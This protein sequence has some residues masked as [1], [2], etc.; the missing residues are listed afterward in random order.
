VWAAGVLLA[1]CGSVSAPEPGSPQITTSAVIVAADGNVPSRNAPQ[2]S[3][4]VGMA[5]RR[6]TWGGM[7]AGGACSTSLDIYWTGAWTYVDNGITRTG[8]LTQN[9]MV[10]LA[11]AAAATRLDRAS[12]TPVCAANH[13]G[14]SVEYAW[15]LPGTSRSAS[16][17]DRPI[18]HGDPLAVELERVAESVSH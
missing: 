9:Q 10:A 3:V 2:P 4:P 16:S 7:C 15:S 6:H 13:D 18:D 11:R 17:C 1:G 5:L 8:T 14:T 12:G